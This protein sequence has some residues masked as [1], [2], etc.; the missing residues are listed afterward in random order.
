MSEHVVCPNSGAD[1]FPP[2]VGE[3]VDAR[4]KELA[5]LVHRGFVALSLGHPVPVEVMDALWEMRK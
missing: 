2:D 5:L 1:L 4:L 3:L